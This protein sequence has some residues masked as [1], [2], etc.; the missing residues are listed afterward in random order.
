ML[1]GKGQQL[2]IAELFWKMYKDAK[3]YPLKSANVFLFARSGAKKI[4][5]STLTVE[6]GSC[7]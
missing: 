3:A 7:S 6:L 1:R 4:G 2:L 5:S